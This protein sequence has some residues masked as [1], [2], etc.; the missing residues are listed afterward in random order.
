MCI[1]TNICARNCSTIWLYARTALSLYGHASPASSSGDGL[2]IHALY[3]ADDDMICCLVQPS[4]AV[5]HDWFSSSLMNECPNALS[6]CRS[7]IFDHGIRG[8]AMSSSSS[9]PPPLISPTA[10]CTGVRFG[11]IFPIANRTNVR[12]ASIVK[13]CNISDISPIVILT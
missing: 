12:R 8:N 9:S 5:I 7:S 3:R 2:L 1:N 11:S 4:L 6:P 10:D 13:L